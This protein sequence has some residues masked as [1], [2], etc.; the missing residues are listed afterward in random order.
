MHTSPSISASIVSAEESSQKYIE[1]SKFKRLNYPDPFNY[2]DEYRPVF[3][4]RHRTLKA[5]LDN[6]PQT[7]ECVYVYGSSLRLDT[8][9]NSDLDVFVIGTMSNAELGEIMRSVPEKEKLDIMV[10]T[11]EEFF[12][13]L[14]NSWND[15]YRK[16]YEGGYKIYEKQRTDVPRS[17]DSSSR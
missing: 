11:R 16:V 1:S 4:L 3:P 7:V 17:L 10:E 15:L 9:F 12:N 13:N 8:A 6:L 14:T 2:G 5:L